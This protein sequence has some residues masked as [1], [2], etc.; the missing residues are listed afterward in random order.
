SVLSA[1]ASFSYSNRPSIPYE[2]MSLLILPDELLH[3]IVAP[4]SYFDIHS[5]MLVSRRLYN[6]M[7]KFDGEKKHLE[8]LKLE[9]CG[10][11]ATHSNPFV[12][13]KLYSDQYHY[14]RSRDLLPPFALKE[15]RRIARWFTFDSVDFRVGLRTPQHVALFHSLTS[16]EAKKMH[17]CDNFNGFSTLVY[18]NA[19]ALSAIMDGPKMSELKLETIIL[20]PDEILSLYEKAVASTHM[21]RFSLMLGQDKVDFLLPAIWGIQQGY[22]NAAVPADTTTTKRGVEICSTTDHLSTL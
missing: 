10:W 1:S 11:R 9:S 12:Q 7:G 16:V 20:R 22:F 6:F 14:N 17:V 21:K 3:K 13:I 8:C 15:L 18:G 19:T 4:L 2:K 5:L